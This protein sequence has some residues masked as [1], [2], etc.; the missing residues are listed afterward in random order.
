MLFY[1]IWWLIL[2][3]MY[4]IEYFKKG[5]QNI[6]KGGTVVLFLLTKFKSFL[7]EFLQFKAWVPPLDLQK[8][9]KIIFDQYLKYER[10]KQQ[11]DDFSCRRKKQTGLL[12]W[13][14]NS[15]EYTPM[16]AQGNKHLWGCNWQESNFIALT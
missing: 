11:S 1:N 7:I 13:S 6:S 9:I 8:H 14:C 12:S 2:W 16:T 3:R 5:K 10:D 15:H 4:L